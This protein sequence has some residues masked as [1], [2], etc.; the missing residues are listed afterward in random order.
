MSHLI[1]EDAR[2]YI[3][4]IFSVESDEEG[5]LLKSRVFLGTAFFVTKR[6]DAITA[7]HVIPE[8]Y[9][10]KKGHRLVAFVHINGKPEACWINKAAKFEAYDLALIQINLTPTKFVEIS[11]ETILAGTD[12]QLIGIPN[13]EVWNQGKEMRLLKGHVTLSGKFLEL[14]FP[15]PAGMSG[16]PV[17][18]ENKVIGYATGQFS[19]EEI[20]EKT[21]EIEQVSDDKEIIHITKTCRIIH[22]GHAFPFSHL[23]KILDPALND[24]TLFEFIADQNSQLAL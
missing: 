13:H 23:D 21:E 24:K 20:E 22:Y 12:V 18:Y 9:N 6:G 4:P 1:L 11:T 8:P 3:V 2:E 19:S 14:N 5:I 17:L 10:I 16:S 7:N 15:V